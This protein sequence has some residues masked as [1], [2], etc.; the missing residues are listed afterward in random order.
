MLEER[1]FDMA[2]AL[3]GIAL[4]ACIAWFARCVNRQRSYRESCR[5][6]LRV[7]AA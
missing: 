6:R 7:A 4:A 5:V 3:E 1:G 2:F